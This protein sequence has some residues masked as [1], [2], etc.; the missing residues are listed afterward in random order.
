MAPSVTTIT[1]QLTG[2]AGASRE[3]WKYTSS[4][5]VAAVTRMSQRTVGRLV[6]AL[7]LV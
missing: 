6:Q 7:A 5:P 4:N 3:T 2:S 1:S